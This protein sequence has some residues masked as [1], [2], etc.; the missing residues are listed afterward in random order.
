MLQQGDIINEKLDPY[1]NESS[2]AFL[3]GEMDISSDW[4]AYVAALEQRGYQTLE[5]IWQTAWERQSN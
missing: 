5:G 3:T 4:D 1:V 2:A